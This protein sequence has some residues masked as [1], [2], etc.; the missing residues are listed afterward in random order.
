MADLNGFQV[1]R[2]GC[3]A[4]AAIAAAMIVV[5]V[6]W[7]FTG[8][9][10][11]T[12]VTVKGGDAQFTY[13]N[14]RV[15]PGPEQMYFQSGV[16]ITK[17]HFEVRRRLWSLFIRIGLAQDDGCIQ[18][19]G[20]ASTHPYLAL[21]TVLTFS[22][23]PDPHIGLTLKDANGISLDSSDGGGFGTADGNRWIFNWFSLKGADLSLTAPLTVTITNEMTGKTLSE[24]SI[25]KW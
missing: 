21:T 11:P 6:A 8:P 12:E 20:N 23:Q 1:M 2:L 24:F 7:V 15:G 5:T 18:L 25:S 14:L 13:C 4:I 3:K 16:P 19:Q 10:N 17:R 22:S 9:S